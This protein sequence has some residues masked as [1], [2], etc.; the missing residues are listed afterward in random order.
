M[1]SEHL[2]TYIDKDMFFN[3]F[4]SLVR[5]HLEYATS[6]WSTQF[7]KDMIAIENVQRRATRFLPCLKGKTYCERLK[8]LGLPKLEYRRERADMVQVY[9]ILNETDKVNK[10]KLFTMSQRTGFRQLG[11]I[12]RNRD[13]LLIG[14]LSPI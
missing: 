7:K 4:K 14:R 9:K 5:P 12:L 10:N 11:K 13:C 1:F 6:V 8:F 3:L 2:R